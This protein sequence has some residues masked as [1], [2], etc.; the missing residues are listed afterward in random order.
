MDGKTVRGSRDSTKNK[1]PL[2]TVSAWGC[3]NRLVFGQEATYEKSNEITAIPKLLALFEIER[4]HCHYR[5]NGP[6][7]GHCRANYQSRRGLFVEA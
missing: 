7:T 4:L 6:T 1:N 5:R 2:H 3:L